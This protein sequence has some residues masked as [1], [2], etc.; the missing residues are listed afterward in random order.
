MK[1][2]VL[3]QPFATLMQ[4]GVKTIETRS[5]PWLYR[6]D[7]AICAAASALRCD[8]PDE[9]IPALRRLWEFRALIPDMPDVPD[10]RDLYLALPRKVC[11]CVVR[12]TGCLDISL[13]PPAISDVERDCGNYNLSPNYP[14]RFAYPTDQLR[15]IR[16]PVPVLGRQGPFEL[17]TDEESKVLEQLSLRA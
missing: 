13:E 4:I 12:K 10:V 3:Y 15:P 2:L 7:V 5:R 17:S 14:R 16:P 8:V 11:V 9:W 6:G 1:A